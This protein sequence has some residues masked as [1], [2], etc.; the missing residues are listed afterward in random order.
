MN[1]TENKKKMP[2]DRLEI[3]FFTMW[4]Y[5][6][7]HV[8]ICVILESASLMSFTLPQHH[9][10]QK[11]ADLQLWI[12]TLG[13]EHFITLSFFFLSFE[14]QAATKWSLFQCDSQNQESR[15]G[16]G[17]VRNLRQKCLP[18]FQSR[19]IWKSRRRESPERTALWCQHWGW[20]P[21]RS[22]VA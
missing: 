4:E 19:R 17:M 15:M 12:K 22:C 18:G 7:G 16:Q 2:M 5:H 14:K 10:H 11:F 13:E 21:W 3:F 20:G 1:N 8:P 6:S 9:A